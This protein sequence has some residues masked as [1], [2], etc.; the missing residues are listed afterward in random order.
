LGGI[1]KGYCA[2]VVNEMFDE[3]G[4]EYGVFN[5]GY[6]SMSIKKSY[7]SSD[8]NWSLSIDDPRVNYGTYLK[9]SV[10]S[11]C[12]ST[13]GDNEK[14]YEI[15]GTRYCHIIDS[16]TGS[17]IQT[18]IASVTI[19]GGSAAEDD[20]LTTALSAMGLEKAVVFINEKLTDRKVIMLYAGGDVPEIITNVPDEIT[21][22]NSNYKVANTVQDG[23]IVLN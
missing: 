8:G 21:I 18:G 14:Y 20:A 5:F 13:S 2:D 4:F 11:V 16:T 6:S 7:E 17:P 10:S 12:L 23:K 19:I 1:G 9:L 15:D 22:L 3:Y